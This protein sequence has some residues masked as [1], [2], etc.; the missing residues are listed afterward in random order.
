MKRYSCQYHLKNINRKSVTLDIYGLD[1]KNRYINIEIQTYKSGSSVKRARYHISTIDTSIHGPK[2]KW[3]DLKEVYVIFITDKDYL[4]KGK[5][6]Y[7]ID[8]DSEDMN[9]NDGT[10]IIYV[11]GENT[12]D[13]PL[14]RLMHD[15]H[16]RF[17]EDMHDSILKEKVMSIKS[18]YEEVKK[19]CKEVER[20]A[21]KEAEKYA[22]KMKKEYAEK[23]KKE[24]AEKMKKEYAEKILKDKKSIASKLLHQGLSVEKISEA[25]SLSINDVKSLVV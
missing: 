15:F 7:Y 12:D 21:R 13:T 9:I 24:Y 19:M 5:S 14:G 17:P 10:H 1:D 3:K 11:N 4:G 16:C 22:E 25:T 2:T 6:I 8:R 23:M 20:Y 18:N